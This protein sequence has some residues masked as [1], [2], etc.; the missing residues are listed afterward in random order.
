MI[1][2]LIV[3]DDFRI[4]E[5]HQSLLESIDGIKVV[6][7]A[8][9][10]EE[11]WSF[12]ETHKVDLLLVDVYMPDQLGIDL[13]IELKK[14]YSHLDYIMITA[15]R[16]TNLL[17]RSLKAG[18][19]Y[20]LIKP[21]ELEKLREVIE[22]YKTQKEIMLSNEFVDQKMVDLVFRISSTESKSNEYLPKGINEL[23]LSKVLEIVKSL[24]DGTTA[25][26]MGERL[27]ASRTTARRYMEHLV[28]TG[29]MKAELEYGIVGRPERKY[30]HQ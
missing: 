3:E 24:P 8:L 5:I 2:V 9:R 12:I 11:S 28:S 14:K 17:E 22:L 23:T 15:A 19:F 1:N 13:V 25:E 29:K 20:Y 18:V 16:D 7:K 10:A 6:G 4:A 30:F 21:V 27:G 26:E